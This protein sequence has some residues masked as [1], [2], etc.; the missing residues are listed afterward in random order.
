MGPK[1]EAVCQFV[2]TTGRMAAIGRLDA[3][4]A[5]P[6]LSSPPRP[7]ARDV[8]EM[9]GRPAAGQTPQTRY[10]RPRD[11]CGAQ[12]ARGHRHDLLVDATTGRW[13]GRWLPVG[14][15]IIVAEKTV[16]G[17]VSNGGTAVRPAVK[18]MPEVRPSR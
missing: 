6:A 13:P 14:V 15:G 16:L 10:R 1:V 12:N 11:A 18:P 4:E 17:A 5:L 7:P 9:A 8:R 3:A 2:E